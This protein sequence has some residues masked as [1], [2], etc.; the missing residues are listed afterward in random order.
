MIIN[1]VTVIQAKCWN[2]KTL[3]RHNGRVLHY[4]FPSHFGPLRVPP[5]LQILRIFWMCLHLKHLH[6]RAESH[7]KYY[8]YWLSK[9]YENKIDIHLVGFLDAEAVKVEV[10]P[11]HDAVSPAR[12]VLSVHR[13]DGVRMSK[14]AAKGAAN[15]KL[16][17][18][19]GEASAYVEPAGGEATAVPYRI[20]LVAIRV[21]LQDNAI[22]RSSRQKSFQICIEN[23]K[24]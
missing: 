11:L 13:H 8:N 23:S 15:T 12:R 18:S 14:G 22:S 20:F 1:G 3:Q 19:P 4:V 17:R 9:G 24:R 2:S 5:P 10:L 6:C 16:T 7:L 21:C